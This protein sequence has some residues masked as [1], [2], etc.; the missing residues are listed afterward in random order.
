MIPSK[1]MFSRSVLVVSHPD[2]EIL[3]FSSVVDRVD[4]M[5]FCYI[6]N[7]SNP[8]WGP[9]RR[10]A[11]MA[12]SNKNISC[13]DIDESEVYSD[14]N[15]H[16]P[17]YTSFGIHIVSDSIRVNRYSK[18]FYELKEKLLKELK[19][20]QNVI[21]HNPWGDYGNE[22][23]VQVYKAIKDLQ[24]EFGFALWF[25]NYCS[26]KSIE[27]MFQYVSGFRSD[28]IT[29]DTDKSLAEKMKSIY[30]EYDCWTWYNNWKWFNEECFVL[31]EDFEE[32]NVKEPR[33]HLFPL[34][35]IKLRLSINEKKRFG[36]LN[37]FSTVFKW[38]SAR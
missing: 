30:S 37:V 24:Q 20:Y 10:K 34:N 25:S 18:N 32:Q 38:L 21:T 36:A 19:G 4:K 26:N 22:E 17:M 12:Y 29:L 28:Y 27:L 31:D 14:S 3:W 16:K 13:L 5:V 15:W 11:L 8:S 9:G 6:D 7:E 1:E 2:D 33:G 35:M 23:H